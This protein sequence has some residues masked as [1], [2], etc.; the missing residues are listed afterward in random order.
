[1]T[2]VTDDICNRWHLL[3]MSSV[4]DVI[5][6]IYLFTSIWCLHLS[7]VTDDIWHMMLHLTSDVTSDVTSDICYI[8]SVTLD[9]ICYIR[10]HVYR[11]N[12]TDIWHLTDI[13]HQDWHLTSGLTSDRTDIWHLLHQICY[14]RWHLLHQMTSVTSDDMYTDVT[15]LLH[16]M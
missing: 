5:C 1:M 4:T 8:R 6:Y 7:D 2:S 16:Q 10:W 3:Q 11:C 15:G 14:I 13:W 12:R 9:D